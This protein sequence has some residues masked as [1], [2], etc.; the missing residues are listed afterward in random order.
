MEKEDYEMLAMSD[1]PPFLLFV[2]VFVWWH[3]HQ[4]H[5]DVT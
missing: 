1:T 5:I 2:C 3:A 4:R